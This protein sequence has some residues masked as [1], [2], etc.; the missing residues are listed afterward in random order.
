MSLV[1][2]PREPETVWITAVA[3]FESESGAVTGPHDVLLEG[4]RIARVE[5]AGTAPAGEPAVDGAGATL[6]PG[7][8]DLH[9]HL[10]STH[11][12]PG[13]LR[14]PDVHENL[15][16][17][18][19]AGVTTALDL[20][21][22]SGAVAH[23]RER[24]ARGTL[25][26]PRLYGSGRPFG[27]EGGHPTSSLTST[28]PSLLV[29]LVAPSIAFELTDPSDLE[30]LLARDPERDALKVMLDTIP[31]GVP[32]LSDEGLAALRA[33][34]DRI[35]KRMIVHTGR[36]ED[37]DRA[38]AAGAD[39]LAHAPYGGALS[40]ATIA[41]LKENDVA[42]IA[43]TSVWQ[44]VEDVATGRADLDPLE[45]AVLGRGPERDVERCQA[46]GAPF[47]AVM[48]DWAAGVVSH[49]DERVQ[50]LTRM[51]EAGVRV[52]VGSDS[53]NIGHAAGV[54][55]HQ[56]LDQL[57]EAGF[58][59]AEVL[60]LATW[61]NSRFLDAQGTFGAVR[62]GW[63]ADVLLVEGDPVADPEAIHRIREVWVDGR[64]IE[65]GSR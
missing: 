62:P 23:L 26:G 32:T 34:A 5:P 45:E 6:V 37:V 44:S 64:R 57:R 38:V 53:P 3:V 2:L 63:E 4:G 49:H 28:Y 55:L 8:V 60:S 50:N 7:L 12:L 54:G 13:R 18:L 10:G 17:M 61:A 29:R 42:V 56:E 59:A 27:A 47:P 58:G 52:L 9:V 16:A 15:E 1:D 24:I 21:H 48:A 41:A 22:P 14:L 33:A 11:A 43:T 30:R 19:W 36:P 65:R 51:R 46:G 20:S 39:A 35:G 31:N 25:A 40:D